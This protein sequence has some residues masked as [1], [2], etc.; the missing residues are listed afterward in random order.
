L[1]Q[2]FL[3]ALVWGQFELDSAAIYLPFA[4]LQ[5]FVLAK[6]VRFGAR[7]MTK[8]SQVLV[9][10]LMMLTVFTGD[11]IATALTPMRVFHADFTFKYFFDIHWLMQAGVADD[12]LFHSLFALLGAGGGLY[13]LRKTS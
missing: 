8:W 12:W 13:A 7:V 3:C 4:V 10:V 11:V 9:F 5:G 2:P 6:V 1:F